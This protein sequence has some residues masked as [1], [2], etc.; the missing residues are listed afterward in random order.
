MYRN[1]GVSKENE[2][3]VVS[4]AD[5]YHIFCLFL[6]FLYIIGTPG[7]AIID[8]TPPIIHQ[9]PPAWQWQLHPITLVQPQQ[10]RTSYQHAIMPNPFPII[11][12]ARAFL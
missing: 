9:T 2:F 7:V 8:I 11:V 10:E 3:Y 1:N 6:S 12:L 5:L 4:V